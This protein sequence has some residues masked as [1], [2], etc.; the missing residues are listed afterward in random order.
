MAH[1]NARDRSEPHRRYP[2][3]I[4]EIAQRISGRLLQGAPP[5]GIQRRVIAFHRPP[6]GGHI[7]GEK[8][9]LQGLLLV[10]CAA[11]FG[12]GGALPVSV[13]EPEEKIVEKTFVTKLP[14]E[15]I[16][17]LDRTM[18][19]GQ[20]RRVQKGAS[21]SETKVVKRWY[22]DG[23][24]VKSLVLMTKTVV[25]TNEIYHVGDRNR[26]STRGDFTRKRTMIMEASA[27]C[28]LEFVGKSKNPYATASGAKAV[29]GIIAVDPKV[30]PMGTVMY[31]EGYGL[32]IAG[33]TG[34]AVKG[35]KIDVCMNTLAEMN[36]WGRK[37]V[38]VHILGR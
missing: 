21:G 12:F 18:G 9:M 3:S 26:L 6:V 13:S 30:I 23:K 4:F 1:G 29:R 31:V 11:V 16:F 22:K 25:P 10:S 7:G 28:A 20:L 27:Y 36:R 35:N 19:T 17:R 8:V 2:V 33:D 37:K 14:Y 24:Q 5:S 32:G 15:V 38:R 34:G